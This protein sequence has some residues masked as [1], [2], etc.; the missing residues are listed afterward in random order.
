MG[1]LDVI[2]W[3]FVS[4]LVFITI[5]GISSMRYDKKNLEKEKIKLRKDIEKI[6]KK[7]EDK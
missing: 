3:S 1:I 6:K 5:V 7:M 2:F 4:I